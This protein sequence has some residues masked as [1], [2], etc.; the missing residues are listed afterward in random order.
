MAKNLRFHSERRFG[1][2]GKDYNN[3]E[4]DT[5]VMKIVFLYLFLFCVKIKMHVQI[6]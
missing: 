2:P 6:I 5:G 4:C 1:S 3:K